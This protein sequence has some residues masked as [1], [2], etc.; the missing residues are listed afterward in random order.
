MPDQWPGQTTDVKFPV[1]LAKYFV[2]LQC[3]NIR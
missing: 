1:V 3:V 2:L